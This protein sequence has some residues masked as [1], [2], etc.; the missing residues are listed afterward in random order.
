[1]YVK[2][3][4]LTSEENAKKGANN[5]MESHYFSCVY[6]RENTVRRKFSVSSAEEVGELKT[7][8]TVNDVFSSAVGYHLEEMER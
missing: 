5:D 2:D 3:T 7:T 8:T 1:M 6:L 4:K